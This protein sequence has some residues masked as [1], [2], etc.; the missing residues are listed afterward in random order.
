MKKAA[1]RMLSLLLSLTLLMSSALCVFAVDY[2]DGVTQ[3]DCEESSVKTD[4]LVTEAVKALSEKSLR[5]TVISE[6]FKDATLNSFLTGIY[7]S[8]SQSASV[9]SLVGIDISTKKLSEHLSKYKSVSTALSSATDWDSVNLEKSKWNIKSVPEF[10]DAVG[11]IFAPFNDV[12]YML[13]C[14]GRYKAGIISIPG[15]D[16]YE[17]GLVSM[18]EALGCTYIP[19]AESFKYEASRNRNKMTALITMSL[20]SMLDSILASPSERLC[21][22]VPALADY[23]KNGGLEKSVNALLR[24]LTIHIGDYIQ[25]FTGSQM[26][27]FIMFIQDPSKYTLRFS[28]NITLVMNDMLES[29]EVTLPEIDLDA[30]IS[31][32]G[33]KGGAYRLIITWLIDTLKLNSDKIASLLPKEEGTEQILSIADSVL[34]KDT[35]ELFVFIVSLFTAKEGKALEYQWLSHEYSQT[36]AEYFEGMGEKEVGR[37][38]DGIDETISDFIVEM[39][40]GEPLTDTIKKTVYSNNV[41]TMLTTGLYGALSGE[42]IKIVGQ[43]LSLPHSPNQLS[44]YLTE[45]SLYYAK[46]TLL[47]YSKWES[48][49]SVDWGF[50][51]GDRKGFETA[52]TAVLRPLRPVLEAFLA[53]GTIKVFDSVNISGTNGYNT[54]V[55]PLLEALGCPSKKIKTYEKYIKG[56]GTDKIIT[57]IL[58]PVFAL[59]DKLA[60]RPVY[61]LTA[62]LPNIIFFI[63][64]G[65]LMQCVDNLLY[66]IT[67]LMNEISPDMKLPGVDF[68]EIKN[69]DIISKVTESASS[70]VDGMDIGKPDIRKLEGMGELTQIKSKRT[71]NSER[72]NAEYVKADQKAVLITILNYVI[73]LLGNEENSGMIDSFM[74]GGQSSGGMFDQY[75]AGIGGEMADM[76]TEETILWLYKLFFHERAVVETTQ[77]EYTET[78]IYVEQEKKSQSPLPIIIAVLVLV[79]AG[80]FA[81]VRRDSI[82]DYFS[83]KRERKNAKKQNESNREG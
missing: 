25:L 81:F 8:I 76:T 51:D 40:G 67:E 61:T 68:D 75:S 4:R 49:K 5:D 63:D 37:V 55:I 44:K 6:L 53:N 73:G 83:E 26:I 42:D 11:A 17:K 35:D 10:S 39:S 1:K 69:T 74:G 21:E 34:K 43:I 65:S 48:V 24:P 57:D 14:S 13:L 80:A 56:K 50:K 77:E 31:C 45:R 47:R 3:K 54:A 38:L 60:K 18:L 29:S 27:S 15:D 2:P 82:S 23:I 19:S 12:L 64:N 79:A 20:I 59:I 70:L 22:I 66:P 71:Y 72:V 52:L 32:K 7:S 46:N 30:L 33:D 62:I 36:Q 41:V 9:L 58:N 78:I 28:E 16:G